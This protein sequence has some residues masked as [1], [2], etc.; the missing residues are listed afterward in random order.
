[1]PKFLGEFY[2]ESKSTKS[3]GYKYGTESTVLIKEE[4]EFVSAYYTYYIH[5]KIQDRIKTG[6]QPQTFYENGFLEHLK[7]VKTLFY[8]YK[9]MNLLFPGKFTEWAFAGAN[10]VGDT[11][12]RRE[13][14][15]GG[16]TD[17]TKDF[18]DIEKLFR[19]YRLHLSFDRGGDNFY[20]HKDGSIRYVDTPS[21]SI[22]S[23]EDI[24]K[25]IDLSEELFEDE[26][27][28]KEVENKIKIYGRRIIEIKKQNL[29]VLDGKVVLKK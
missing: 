29:Q 19:K 28:R 13:K 14:V 24:S 3:K 9:I 11:G 17:L 7:R 4:D 5:S 25:I 6:I 18:K 2:S 10:L 1:M 20:Y 21:L 22:E 8:L 27:Q 15:E 23:S 26:K 12:S 16:S